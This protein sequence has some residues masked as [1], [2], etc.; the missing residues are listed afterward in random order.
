MAG[1]LLLTLATIG[2]NPDS[3]AALADLKQ[4]PVHEQQYFA[5]ATVSDRPDAAS[6]QR[7]AETLAFVV[8]SLSHKSYLGDQIPQRVEGTDLYRINLVGLGWEKQW[9]NVL[10]QHYVPKYRPDL[11]LTHQYP[12]VVSALWMATALPDTRESGDSQYLLLYGFTPKTGAEFRKFWKVSPATGDTFGFIEGRSGVQAKGAQRLMM[13]R[14]TSQ[15]AS[16]FETFDSKRVAGKTSPSENLLPGTLTYDGQELIVGIPKHYN[17]EGGQLQAYFL[18]NGN[19]DPD[20]RQHDKRVDF[21]PPDLVRD[22]LGTRGYDIGNGFDCMACH[23]K[24]MQD[25]TI[26][27]Y[28][29]IILNGHKIYADKV[30]KAEI[31]RFYQSPF[32]KELRR[33]DE[34]YATAMRLVNGLTPERNAAQFVRCIK[35]YDA[36]LDLPQAAREVYLTADQL[37]FALAEYSPYLTDALA[38][39]A[40]G[41]PITRDE[42]TDSQP[43]LQL[44]IIPTWRAKK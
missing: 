25:P 19:S 34:D 37:R 17:G 9:A 32:A 16:F 29:A 35:D 28:K 4:F 20:K 12:L 40:H 30:S 31:E 41:K 13:N 6:K 27:E 3:A 18:N 43:L 11:Q 38:G 10:K 5:Y 8:C 14:D 44:K 39:L 15:R 36:D 22:D 33:A 42:W 21:A 2:I 24:G 23:V 1:L 7:T 26:D